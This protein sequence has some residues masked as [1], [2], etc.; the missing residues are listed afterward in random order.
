MIFFIQYIEIDFLRVFRNYYS[1]KWSEK[2]I[3]TSKEIYF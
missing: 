1:K 2:Q 3:F